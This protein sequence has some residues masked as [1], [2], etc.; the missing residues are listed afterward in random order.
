[1]A[2]SG[3]RALI[4]FLVL[5]VLSSNI[6]FSLNAAN[7]QINPVEDK[8]LPDPLEVNV[9]L[10]T[11]IYRRMSVREF[12]D[13][14][15]SEEHLS[16]VLWAAY[17]KRTQG[18]HTV[19]SIDSTYA[20]VL[21]VFNQDAV[22]TYEP[23]NH[24]LIVYKE[25]DH[26]DD[27]DIYQ[28]EAPVQIGL[29]WNTTKADPN[30]A[31]MEL[32]QIGQN[33]Q[34][35]ANALDLGTVVTGQIPPA[36]DP[37]GIPEDQE[38]MIIMPL[39]HPKNKYDFV[40]R[41]MW[42]SPLPEIME[43]TMT[44]S[45]ALI[46]RSEKDSFDGVLSDQEKSQIIWSTYGFSPFIDKS[47]QEPIHLKRHRTVP[48]AHGYYPLVIYSVTEEGIYR[49]YPN[50]LTNL[51]IDYLKVSSAPV[52]FFGLP[53]VTMLQKTSSIDVREAI[54]QITN[55]SALSS[56]SLIIIPVLDVEKTK[57]L[58]GESARRFWYYEGGAVCHN[59]M[60]EATAWNLNT[61][62]IY[63]VD[64]DF[65]RSELSLGNQFIPIAVIP[66]GKS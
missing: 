62:I 51:L 1:M 39:G 63:P 5:I 43:S 10:E 54:A 19:S 22:Y 31:G 16:T 29:C 47:D 46:K 59:V 8:Q 18:D 3:K 36:I 6:V 25:G 7:N 9:L 55:E 4:C 14:P 34:F 28:Y 45:E 65:I 41:P 12:T 60:L 11:S 24:S 35:M 20:T 33:I 44:L 27:I 61:K 2:Y 56:A 30:Q 64:A 49:Y 21:Y 40:D 37:V 42:I 53:I 52:D 38:G 32:G 57:E 15:V 66:V 23:K 50:V 26:R 58:S 13:Q 17:G 48:S